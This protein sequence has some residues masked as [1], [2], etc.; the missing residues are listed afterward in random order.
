MARRTVTDG[1]ALD[2][3]AQARGTA[4]PGQDEGN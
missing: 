3:S 2:G 4:R 1:G